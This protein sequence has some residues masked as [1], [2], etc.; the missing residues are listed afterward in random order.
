M[1]NGA[2]STNVATPPPALVRRLRVVRLL[3]LT[4]QGPARL[5]W[6]GTFSL[7]GSEA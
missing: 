7:Q 2:T 5:W 3:A 4:M 1:S 6:G